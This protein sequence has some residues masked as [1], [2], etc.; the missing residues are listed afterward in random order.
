MIMKMKKL[1]SLP[2]TTKTKYRT[3]QDIELAFNHLMVQ[4]RQID[5]K[6]GLMVSKEV[7]NLFDDC[8]YLINQ[9]KD[10]IRSMEINDHKNGREMN[11]NAE[12]HRI[13]NK[14]SKTTRKFKTKI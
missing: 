5:E 10:F 2:Y 3:N 8:R 7:N 4:F 13:N 14:I 9:S 6:Y 12:A 11:D 1:Q